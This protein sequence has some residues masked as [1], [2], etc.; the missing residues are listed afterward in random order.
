MAWNEFEQLKELGIKGTQN[1]FKII[2]ESVAS[3]SKSNEQREE[4]PFMQ[5]SSKHKKSEAPLF[6]LKNRLATAE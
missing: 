5:G 1:L 2:D 3:Q 6:S 4:K